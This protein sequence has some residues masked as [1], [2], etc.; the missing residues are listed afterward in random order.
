MKISELELPEGFSVEEIV[1]DFIYLN[2]FDEVVAVFNWVS[3][4]PREIRKEANKFERAFKIY[5]KVHKK[6]K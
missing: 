4:D 2:Y 3:A 5:E 1:D 6:D